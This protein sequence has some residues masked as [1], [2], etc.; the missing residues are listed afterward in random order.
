MKAY[1]KRQTGH[2]LALHMLLEQIEPMKHIQNIIYP[3]T[4]DAEGFGGPVNVHDRA[5]IPLTKYAQKALAKHC[6]GASLPGDLDLARG[7]SIINFS[8]SRDM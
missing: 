1:L 3:A 4:L 6:Q 8:S 2:S 5:W 7:F